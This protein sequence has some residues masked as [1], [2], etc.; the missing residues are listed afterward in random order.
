MATRYTAFISYSHKDTVW[1]RWLQ[2]QLETYRVPKAFSHA[3]KTSQK[4]GKVF[5]DRDDLASGQNLSE[6]L[7]Q[8]SSTL[9]IYW[10]FAHPARQYRLGSIKK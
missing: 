9:I 6:H 2:R 10:L 3:H 7:T 8:A 4:L 1:A 5:R